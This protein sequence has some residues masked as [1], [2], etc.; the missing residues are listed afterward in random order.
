[1][2]VVTCKSHEPMLLC[3]INGSH[4]VPKHFCKLELHGDDVI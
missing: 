3:V 1:M 4:S 2:D